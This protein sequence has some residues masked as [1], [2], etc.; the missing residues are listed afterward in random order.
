MSLRTPGDVPD[1]VVA[2]SAS[3][4]LSKKMDGLLMDQEVE[5]VRSLTQS[6]GSGALLVKLDVEALALR[7]AIQLAVGDTVSTDDLFQSI[8][9]AD[10][11]RL[12]G[13]TSLVFGSVADIRS[14]LDSEKAR[15]SQLIERMRV[16]HAEGRLASQNRALQAQVLMLSAHQDGRR[17][18]DEVMRNL[19]DDLEV[20]AH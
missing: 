8:A 4:F 15:I 14:R 6:E 13:P 7:D 5:F 12:H 17:A 1:S 20:I 11:S 2:L 3:H 10:A 19:W 9:I 16:L 18:P